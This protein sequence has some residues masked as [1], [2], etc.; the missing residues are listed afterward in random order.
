[1][2][3]SPTSRH[4]RTPRRRL[5]VCAA[6]VAATTVSVGLPADAAVPERASLTAPEIGD[7][8]DDALDSLAEAGAQRSF[9]K[10][11][12][13]AHERDIVATVAAESLGIDEETMRQ[14]WAKADVPHQRALLAAVSQLGVPYRS[15]ASEENVGFD[16]SGL[17]SYAWGRAGVGIAHQSSSQIDAA[18]S[19]TRD[20][21][22]AGD[23]VQYPGHV[24]MYLGVGNA[25]V[26]SPYTGST[27]EITTL[28]DSHV[29]SVRFGN[30][31][32]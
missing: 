1:M 17:T 11:A 24:M 3:P 29:D 8:A 20:T 21:A 9:G 5:A 15:M 13:Y 27:V 31:I 22:M 10:L 18:A 26:H 4:A 23:L 30:P 28:S 19:R 32:G 2:R 25:I 7:L 12:Q 6:V 14:A 16:C